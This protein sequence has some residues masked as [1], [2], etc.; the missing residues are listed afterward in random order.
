VIDISLALVTDGKI[1][2]DMVG[3]HTDLLDEFPF[4]GN[5]HV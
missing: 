2:T 4:V 1:T 5:P 3:P